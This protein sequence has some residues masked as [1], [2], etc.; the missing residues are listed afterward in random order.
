M[1]AGAW[2]ED[3]ALAYSSLNN[4]T[5]PKFTATAAQPRGPR[6][7]QGLALR[8]TLHSRSRHA[9]AAATAAVPLS[10]AVAARRRGGRGVLA[11]LKHRTPTHPVA[12]GARAHPPPLSSAQRP[13]RAHEEMG[14]HEEP[15]RL[16]PELR[17]PSSSPC[18]REASC[19]GDRSGRLRASLVTWGEPGT[20]PR[21]P[22]KKS[23]AATVHLQSKEP[24]KQMWPRSSMGP[25]ASQGDTGGTGGA[26]EVG[27][28]GGSRPRGGLAP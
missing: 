15:V 3:G 19:V 28:E 24:S 8:C 14:A 18:W 1:S 5:N 4:Q 2:K 22:R 26:P 7:P 11:V 9:P 6:P 23:F 17:V 20:V 21:S 13:P 27:A 12:R 10:P 16:L 25:G